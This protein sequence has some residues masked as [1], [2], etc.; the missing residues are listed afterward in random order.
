MVRT[1]GFS[2]A[3]LIQLGYEI[4]KKGD[5]DEKRDK[6]VIISAFECLIVCLW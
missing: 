1:L 6:V 5:R 4:S 3:D 2:V